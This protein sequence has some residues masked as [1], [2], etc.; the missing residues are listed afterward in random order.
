VNEVDNEALQNQY[1]YASM[2]A[3]QAALNRQLEALATAREH[4]A[5]AMK[6][7]LETAISKAMMPTEVSDLD[8]QATKLGTY[9]DKWDEFARRADAI[10]KG[11]DPS[12][13]GDKWASAFQRL[14][15]P[16]EEAA[17][18]FR[19]FSLFAGG[20]NMDLLADSWEKITGNIAEQLDSLLGES[21]VKEK[22]FN[23][24]WSRLSE[25]KR[26]ALRQLGIEKLTDADKMALGV[27][28][29]SDFDMNLKGI[30][31]S[32]PTE[33][34]IKINVEGG[35]G[36]GTGNG[37]LP[38]AALS[39]GEYVP[40]ST[41]GG[42]MAMQGGGRGVVTRSG[43]VWIDRGEQYW[44]SGTRNQVPAPAGININMG[45]VNVNS[46]RDAVRLA[47]DLVREI[48]RRS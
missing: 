28:K 21:Q 33:V 2:L 32:I 36:G 16:A 25:D 15:M 17:R 35:T 13:Y 19:D 9:S 48:Q 24:V 37:A 43:Y 1:R 30:L 40:V 26:A 10:A 42:I 23:E 29:A 39:Q 12:I 44:A 20:K 47:R 6:G 4:L 34:S 22:A 5:T 38:P 11:T 7:I 31:D 8:I 27:R 45:G 41:P 14:A 46:Q 18:R 3:D